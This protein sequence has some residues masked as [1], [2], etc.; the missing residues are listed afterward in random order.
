MFIGSSVSEK[1]YKKQNLRSKSMSFKADQAPTNTALNTFNGVKPGQ[2]IQSSVPKT[3]PAIPSYSNN[4]PVV[5]QQLVTD[6]FNG[7]TQKNNANSGKV[8]DKV[9][10]YSGVTALVATPIALVVSHNISAKNTKAVGEELLKKFTEVTSE[11]TKKLDDGKVLQDGIKTQLTEVTGKGEVNN[12]LLLGLAA[13]LS[14]LFGVDILT[15]TST[16]ITEVKKVD[17]A[18]KAPELSEA[19]VDLLETEATKR[20]EGKYPWTK[21]DNINA[22]MVTSETQSFMKV[23]G[24]A[25][26][27]VQLPDA[28]NK[29]HEG[30]P[31]NKMVIVTPLYVGSDGDRKSASIQE[32]D[33]THFV[34]KGAEKQEVNLEKLGTIPVKVYNEEKKSYKTDDVDILTG[35]LNGTKYIFL[36]D[37][38]MFNISP[39]RDN[40]PKCKGPYVKS[41]NGI[42]EHERMA[43]LSKVT[44][45]LIKNVKTNGVDAPN[46]IVANDW[47]ASAI[48]ALMRYD[49]PVVHEQKKISDETYE[50]IKN[51]PIIHITHNAQFVGDVD[52]IGDRLFKTQ[53][54]ENKDVINHNIRGYNGNKDD[55]PLAKG[56]LGHYTEGLSDLYLADR[57]VAVSNNYAEELCKA[58]DLGCGQE[59]IN[60]IRK[61]NGTMLGIVNGYTKSLSEPNEKFINNNINNRLS[62]KKPFIP[63]ANM[64]DDE[65]YKIKLEN[66]AN[67]VELLNE[68]AKKAIDGQELNGNAKL[69]KPESCKI[70]TDIDITKVPFLATVGRFDPQKGYDYLAES[71]KLVLKDLKP[72]QE[73][74]IVAVLGNGGDDVLGKLKELKD[75]VSKMN[76][77]AGQRI[78]IFDGFSA[79]IKDALG[80]ASDFFMIPSKW[81]PCGLTQMESMPK[82]SLP[83]ATATGG[84]VDTIKD[85]EDGFV[86]DVFYGHLTNEEIYNN[87]K[88]GINKPANNVIA[89]A[90]KVQKALDTYYTNPD[91][92]K[93]MAI[94]AM[95]RD[96]SWDVPGGA[97]DQYE[98][99]MRTGKVTNKAS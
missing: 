90:I 92:I 89:Y 59:Y 25:E 10:K 29:K 14:A 79:P 11:L 28:F 6:A 62:P 80:V 15:N 98:E 33:D 57:S 52:G 60:N 95:S 74:P 83:I 86:T 64:Y 76:P 68:M 46:V 49:A 54:E 2:N 53:F 96:F 66:K 5:K 37:D 93:E 69:Y 47:H 26:V 81:E 24:L 65:G 73:P 17:D 31:N 61:A 44:Y 84:L 94:N 55:F 42:G 71:L 32:L 16:K 70:P 39:A 38:K 7:E 1:S 27:A 18:P 23:G 56:G 72:G 87:G 19:T 67:M 51:T 9:L 4:S 40:D 8:L 88:T 78:F 48:S 13:G 12:K 20:I 91:K 97:L 43:F 58:K 41:N 50:H 36:R 82:G 35:T 30:D 77:E 99:L 22:W 3:Q 85:G 34:Y 21:I 63:Y 45:E 75:E